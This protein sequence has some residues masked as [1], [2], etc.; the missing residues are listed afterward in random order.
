MLILDLWFLRLCC[1]ASWRKASTWDRRSKTPTRHATLNIYICIQM[2]LCQSFFTKNHRDCFILQEIHRPSIGTQG[3]V[4]EMH[5]REETF[6]FL[7]LLQWIWFVVKLW[8]NQTVFRRSASSSG[9]SSATNFVS[10]V[11]W[12]WPGLPG[13]QNAK[14]KIIF[15]LTVTKENL[16]MLF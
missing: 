13:R 14:C 11:T 10:G 15:I 6:S 4:H 12:G 1:T 5:L 8:W 9:R 3:K 2:E 7:I 16:A